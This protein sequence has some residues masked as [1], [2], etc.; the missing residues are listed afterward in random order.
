[1]KKTIC[2]V[3]LGILFL[4]FTN[5][6]A[7]QAAETTL[8]SYSLSNFGILQFHVP[9]DWKDDVSQPKDCPEP[10]ISF[11][12]KSGKPF[13]ILVTPFRPADPA[14]PPPDDAV[15]NRGV[16][17]MIEKIRSRAQES[18]IDVRELKRGSVS[19]YYFL[20]TDRA[21][22][23]GGYQYMN[24]GLVRVGKWFLFFTILTNEGQGAVVSSGL[25]MLSG[26]VSE[27][28]GAHKDTGLSQKLI[29]VRQRNGR[30]E[31]TAPYSRLVLIEDKSAGGGG[32]PDHPGYF[33]FAGGDSGIILS[34]WFEPAGAFEGKEKYFA[35][36]R[37]KISNLGPFLPE[38][39][40]TSEIDTWDV[41]TY[42]LRL[43]DR[44]ELVHWNLRA[45]CVRENT[46]ID[47]HISSGISRDKLIAF[48][49]SVQI[50]TKQQ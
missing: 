9:A 25:E 4:L 1:M 36:I 48:L 38:N 16:Q 41:M 11:K 30:L 10:T 45:S 43:K 35:T 21:P 18:R 49:K 31:L 22:E 8:R 13:S 12:P 33:Y 32:G 15:L 50:E 44:P 7:S 5:I 40:A 37:E 20:A 14:M 19:G 47:L 34:G 26:A 3:S 42:S 23:E 24:Q 28:S 39:T 2:A 46:W 17:R 6:A 29:Q 27:E